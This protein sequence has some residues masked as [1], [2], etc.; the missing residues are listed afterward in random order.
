MPQLR[1]AIHNIHFYLT[2]NDW[3]VSFWPDDYGV[4]Q[5]PYF[6]HIWELGWKNKNK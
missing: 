5:N 4:T 6:E 3:D 1:S 2:Y